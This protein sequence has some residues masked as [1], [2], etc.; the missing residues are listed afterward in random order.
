[1]TTP[2]KLMLVCIVIEALYM[3]WLTW[4]FS[5]LKQSVDELFRRNV[6]TNNW[7]WRIDKS[8]TKL[9]KEHMKEEIK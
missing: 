8:L 5:D 6:Y 1:M 3:A 4:H 2:E 7:I 9:I